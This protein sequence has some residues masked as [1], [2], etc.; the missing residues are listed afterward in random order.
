MSL[1]LSSVE[2]IALP[3]KKNLQQKKKLHASVFRNAKTF[4]SFLSKTGVQYLEG[5]NWGAFVVLQH[6][7][8][9]KH[10]VSR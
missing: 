10:F 2:E 6:C 1:S 5:V 8:K 4:E 9:P 7:T 3:L